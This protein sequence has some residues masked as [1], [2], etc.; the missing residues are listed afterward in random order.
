[1]AR[2][3]RLASLAILVTALHHPAL[4]APD[5]RSA[6][7]PDTT[8]VILLGTGMPAPDPKAQGPATA[9]TIGSRLF[10]F[11]A[12]PGVERQMA[13]ANLP[14]RHGP[15]TAAFLTHLHS[16]HTL[17]L[18]DLILTSWVMGRSAPLRL[19]GPPGTRA[20]VDHILRAWSEDIRVRTEGLEHGVR[21][22]QAVNVRETTGGV[23]YDSA[24]VR[25]AAIPVPHG[26]W[27]H[28]FAYRID[29]P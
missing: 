24:G 19:V 17:G 3:V 18:P 21:G 25:I 23:V 27:K 5:S 20:M 22:G 6:P 7:I 29:T 26:S 16:D 2:T 12:G 10:L 4:A 14:Y 8:Q 11:D 15:V 13:A 1:M 28:A 9:V